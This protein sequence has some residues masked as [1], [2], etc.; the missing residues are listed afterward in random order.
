MSFPEKRRTAR[1]DLP[2]TS[3][4]ARL[5]QFQDSHSS[6]NVV[7]VKNWSSVPVGVADVTNVL[8][9]LE[10]LM[11][12]EYFNLKKVHELQQR[13]ANLNIYAFLLTI[14]M[15]RCGDPDF[16]LDWTRVHAANIVMAGYPDRVP[17]R[18]HA[19]D[20]VMAENPDYLRESYVSCVGKLKLAS[21]NVYQEL[22]INSWD[23][24]WHPP[25]WQSPD[26]E[27]SRFISIY[28][29]Q[30][31]RPRVLP[32]LLPGSLTEIDLELLEPIQTQW[33]NNA[34]T[35]IEQGASLAPALAMSVA[36]LPGARERIVATQGDADPY[37]QHWI[38]D[39][40]GRARGPLIE[41]SSLFGSTYPRPLVA[42]DIATLLGGTFESEHLL[43][44]SWTCHI[45]NGAR[46][47]VFMIV[48]D[49]E[50]GTWDFVTKDCNQFRRPELINRSYCIKAWSYRRTRDPPQPLSRPPPFFTVR[51]RTRIY[52]KN[53]L[54]P[55]GVLSFVIITDPPPMVQIR[56]LPFR[57]LT[58]VL[59]EANN[60]YEQGGCAI[61]SRMLLYKKGETYLGVDLDAIVWPPNFDPDMPLLDRYLYVKDLILDRSPNELSILWPNVAAPVLTHPEAPRHTVHAFIKPGQRLGS[62]GQ[63]PT[64]LYI[65]DGRYNIEEEDGS[66]GERCADTQNY[67]HQLWRP[68]RNERERTAP[69]YKS[70]VER[71]ANVLKMDTPSRIQLCWSTDD[72]V[73]QEAFDFETNDIVSI[74]D[75][76]T[77]R[78]YCYERSSVV[79][80][81]TTGKV[82]HRWEGGRVTGHLDHSAP[83]YLGLPELRTIVDQQGI[84][85]VRVS[86]ATLF[87]L[88][89]L[90]PRNLGH[91]DSFGYVGFFGRE[92]VFTFVP[93]TDEEGKR[94]GLTYEIVP[95]SS[96]VVLDDP[97][98]EKKDPADD[99]D[100]AMAIAGLPLRRPADALNDGREFPEDGRNVRPRLEPPE[101]D[102]EFDEFDY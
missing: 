102:D 1:F 84:E 86:G 33:V 100:L 7:T 99:Q 38:S 95:N 20:N 44:P 56:I 80:A 36:S 28:H 87:L 83:F 23:H 5:K 42:Y 53:Q 79:R 52:T 24:D 85:N 74:I 39:Y 98:E 59:F 64:R 73:T 65:V 43:G 91:T 90:G 58:G 49:F 71:P 66:S 10:P 92:D 26:N 41:F 89:N 62:G 61:Q 18:V 31:L 21:Q 94:L 46:T 17:D 76:A 30:N 82:F 8:L 70:W 72:V 6:A 35:L 75:P 60:L 40:D 57:R 88:K 77:T 55:G 67:Y 4:A 50:S 11:D 34:I 15:T 12:R 93:L 54:G 37:V 97:E 27:V 25:Y 96:A 32:Q 14:D 3:Q 16:S 9:S 51:D 68:F 63:V 81:G 47:R 29:R 69:R 2:D 101:S 13:N 19:A 45:D 78:A 22:G 48:K